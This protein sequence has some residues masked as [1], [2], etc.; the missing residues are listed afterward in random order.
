MQ[1][2][3][4][5]FKGSGDPLQLLYAGEQEP[6]FQSSL[7]EEV[8]VL[9]IG[10]GPAGQL[11]GTQLSRFP[12]ITTRII[13]SK[14]ARLEQGQADGLQC[15][16]I[17]IFEAFGF[18]E[19]VL[20][21]AYWV[22]ETTFWSPTED[23]KGL[24]R[25]GRIRD[26]EEG[27]SEF[28][29]V[30]LNQAR[31]HD[32]WLDAMKGSA[33]RLEP[34]YSRQMSSMRIP[35][36]GP[37]E[38]EIERV[39]EAHKGQK[40][41]VR[42]KYV[43]GCDG[44]RSGVRRAM[45]YEMKGDFAN[46]AWGVMDAL[47]VTDFPDLRLKT[48][49]HSANEGSILIIPREGGYLARF[50]IEMDKLNPNERIASKKV[51]AES[52]IDTAKRIFHPF[53][54]DVRHIAYWSVYEVGQRL[55]DHFDDVPKAERDQRNP[56]V[57]IAGDAC[58]THSAKAGQGMNVSMNDAYNLGWKIASVLHGTANPKLLHTYNDERQGI[59][60][61][62]IDFDRKIS[63]LFAAKP[64]GKD[65][66]DDKDAID[67]AVFQ[68]YF[69]QQGRFMAG[70]ATKYSPGILTSSDTSHQDLAKGFE[71][72]IRFQSC[73]V[74]RLADAKPVQLGHV[75]TADG[76]WRLVLFGDKA[77]PISPSSPLHQTCEFLLNTLIPK[78]TPA[79][80]DIDSVLDV[81]AVLQQ[82]RKNISISELPEILLPRKGVFG[83]QDYEKVFTDEASYGYGFG[84][85]CKNRG[86]DAEKGCVIVV[87]PD[88]YVSAVVPLG[89][90]GQGMLEAF[91]GGFMRVQSGK[92]G[93]NGTN[94]HM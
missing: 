38:V 17:E 50:Y 19:R 40:E 31:L 24:R 61:L 51:T 60:K 13:E 54:F 6:D 47:V 94:G 43:V 57:F 20:K 11:L 62:L 1:F 75:M 81:R 70:V 53:S 22:N 78:Y 16:T 18:S 33:T 87:R 30:I 91:F 42:A 92:N 56:R 25:T 85:I 76:R 12:N 37:V 48:A 69:E 89:E 90:A 66:T 67:P 77:D 63:K 23:G 36:A 64:K 74:L 86:I 32:L 27:L 73:Q 58:H 4:N 72:G 3:L 46:Q 45:G 35:E 49:I 52:L 84:E 5:G 9:I 29:H 26:T 71:I 80:A 83:I 65:G 39:D 21:E 15:R 68:E 41:T 28:P 8:D 2:H 79:K 10:A 93:S 34:S 14:P 88:Q 55:T 82:S 7:P 59:A 44:A